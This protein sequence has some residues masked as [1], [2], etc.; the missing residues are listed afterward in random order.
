MLDTARTAA[1]KTTCEV[2]IIIPPEVFVSKSFLT[3]GTHG[4]LRITAA[5]NKKILFINVV[6]MDKSIKA[7]PFS[8]NSD[9]KK[10][11]SKDRLSK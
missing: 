1:L 8:P 7:F 5:V 9:L 4:M 6:C 2:P 11:P 10:S 3:F